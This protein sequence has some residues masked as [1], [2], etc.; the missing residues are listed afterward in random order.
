MAT[1][2]QHSPVRRASVPLTAIDVEQLE[3]LRSDGPEHQALLSLVG[4]DAHSVT[5]AALLHALIDLAL[6]QV[7]ERAEEAGY[8]EL[9]A[10]RDDRSR[11]ASARRRPPSWAGE[12]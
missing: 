11:R 9:A 10:G 6:H 12:S 1:R 5:E 8:A 2:M 4:M 3:R 7:A